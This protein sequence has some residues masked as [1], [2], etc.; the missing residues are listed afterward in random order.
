MLIWVTVGMGKTIMIASLLHTN[1]FLS[2]PLPS[3][4]SSSFKPNDQLLPDEPKGKSKFRQVRLQAA[5]KNHS[6]VKPTANDAPRPHRGDPQRVPSVTLVVAPTS[7]LSQWGEELKRSSKEGTI[8]VHIWHGQNRFSLH[9]ALYPDEVEY[10]DDD[11]GSEDIES[12]SDKDEDMD[13]A[14]KLESEAEGVDSDEWKPKARSK[15]VTKTKAKDKKKIQVVVTSYGVLASE[16]AKYEKSARKSES[17]VFESRSAI[18]GASTL[19][20]ALT[21]R[22]AP[23]CSG[24]S[25]S[26]QIPV[27]QDRQSGLRLEDEKKMGRHGH[28]DRESARRLVF[29][30]VRSHPGLPGTG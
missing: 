24:R 30:L 10:I 23:C 7:L 26:L 14:G 6:N 3:S 2:D 20:I 28:A 8:E 25:A 27:Q 17:S 5:F 12:P 29:P 15:N 19:L 13:V 18:S 1:R 21:S 11:S 9:E 4:P 16:H 22:M